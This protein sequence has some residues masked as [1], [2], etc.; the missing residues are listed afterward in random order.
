MGEGLQSGDHQ[1]GLSTPSCTQ[2]DFS[3][4]NLEQLQ[5]DDQE[6]FR[7]A[8]VC[9]FIDH[10]LLAGATLMLLVIYGVEAPEWRFSAP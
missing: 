3:P 7:C 2:F 9:V 8:C 5:E 4:N 6:T 10:V 1:E